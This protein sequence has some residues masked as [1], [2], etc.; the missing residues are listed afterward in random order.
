MEAL[1]QLSIDKPQHW[2]TREG[3]PAYGATL[4]E[5]RKQGLLPSITNILQCWPR[6]GLERYKRE[7]DILAALTTPRLAEEGD[8]AFC[9]RIIE[10][11]EAHAKDAADFGTEIHKLFADLLTEFGSGVTLISIAH[12]PRYR[13]LSQWIEDTISQVH[14]IEECFVSPTYGYGCRADALVTFQGKMVVSGVGAAISAPN[15]VLLDLKTQGAKEGKLVFYDTWAMQ[16]AAEEECVKVSPRPITLANLVIDSTKPSPPVLK[17]LTEA[18]LDKAW[19][20][21][22]ACFNLWKRVKNYD[23]LNP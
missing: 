20:D 1:N 18:E 15:D 9:K 5:A 23:P 22:L 16:L 17:V 7:Q 21:F 3:E 6:P 8:T 4:R 19:D 14:W 13:I 12:H 10:D 11:S 2:Y